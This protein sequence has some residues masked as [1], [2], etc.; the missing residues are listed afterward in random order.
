[1]CASLAARAQMETETI[2]SA[3]QKQKAENE[4]RSCAPDG[5]DLIKP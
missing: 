1:M 5:A 2:R 3:N 4:R